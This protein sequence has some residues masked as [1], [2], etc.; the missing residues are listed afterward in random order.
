[1]K[2]YSFSIENKKTGEVREQRCEA[3]SELKAI[4]KMLRRKHWQ[5]MIQESLFKPIIIK[6]TH[7]GEISE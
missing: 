5:E 2:I 7:I 4:D 3:D 1:M 6:V